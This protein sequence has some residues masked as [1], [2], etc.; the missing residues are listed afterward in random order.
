MDIAGLGGIVC[1]SA[2][3]SNDSTPSN[4]FLFC[5]FGYWRKMR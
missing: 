1:L 2:S 3:G 4:L 5:E